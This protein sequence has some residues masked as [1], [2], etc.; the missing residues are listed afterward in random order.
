[1]NSDFY[2]NKFIINTFIAGFFSN[3]AAWLGLY[4]NGSEP[5]NCP[6][7][8]REGWQWAD[9]SPVTYTN[10][11]NNEPSRSDDYAI[12]MRYDGSSWFADPLR[13]NRPFICKRGTQVYFAFTGR[14]LY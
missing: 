3:R 5:E 14:L 2:K 13:V 12:F 4:R 8:C 9:G 7:P 11:A 6:F 10:W 1:M